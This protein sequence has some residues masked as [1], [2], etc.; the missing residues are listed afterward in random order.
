MVASFGY[1][2]SLLLTQGEF[3]HTVVLM[4][5]VARLARVCD[6]LIDVIIIIIIMSMLYIYIFI[7]RTCALYVILWG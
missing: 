7:N 2:P 1:Y 3:S 4:F 5:V 6:W